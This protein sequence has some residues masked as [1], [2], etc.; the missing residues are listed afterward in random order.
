MSRYDDATITLDDD[1]ITIHHHARP[2]RSRRISWADIRNAE[3]I[4]LR[5]G[6][7]RY[8][9]VGYSFGRPRHFFHWDRSRTAKRDGISLD[10]GGWRRLAITPDD[11]HRVLALIRERVTTV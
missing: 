11:P 6:T 4:P 10:T 5:F 8:R 7:G 3:L 9:L 1:G 2:G